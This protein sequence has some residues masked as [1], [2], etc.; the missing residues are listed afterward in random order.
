MASDLDSPCGLV[1]SMPCDL[2]AT[3]PAIVEVLFACE[4]AH[5]RRHAASTLLVRTS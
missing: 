4:L 5:R 1:S 2:E 3:Q